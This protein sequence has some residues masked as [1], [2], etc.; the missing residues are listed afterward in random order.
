MLQKPVREVLLGAATGKRI[1]LTENFPCCPQSTQVSAEVT[2]KR[3]KWYIHSCIT[4]TGQVFGR[5]RCILKDGVD[6]REMKWC[7]QVHTPRQRHEG[8]NWHG[9]DHRVVKYTTAK[10]ISKLK[11]IYHGIHRPHV[12]D[13]GIFTSNAH[14]PV[15][16]Q[17][18]WADKT[19]K[20][21]FGVRGM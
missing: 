2:F 11:I 1:L 6:V 5:K 15:H 3:H 16:I 8:Y 10:C 19:E 9:Y 17:N 20:R 14:I 4:V 18:T 7:Y 21:I 12:W 13:M